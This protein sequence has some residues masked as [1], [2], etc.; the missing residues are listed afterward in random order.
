MA[1][2]AGG[3]GAQGGGGSDFRRVDSGDFSRNHC[4]LISEEF[5]RVLSVLRGAGAGATS[6]SQEAV[7]SFD[8]GNGKIVW[9]FLTSKLK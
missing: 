1:E 3:E 5:G 6:H 4:Q 2:A 7:I 8:G 9:K